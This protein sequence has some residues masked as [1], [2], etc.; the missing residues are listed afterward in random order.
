MNAAGWERAKS[1]LADAAALPDADRERF[2]VERCP[3]LELRREVLELLLSPAP[4]RDIVAA[5]TLHPGARIG[6]YVID[7]L[8]GRGGMGEV[9]RATDTNLKR[10]VAIKVLPAAVSSDPDRLARF[11][12]EAEV[13]AALNHPNVAHIHGLEKADG[14]IALVMEL[15]EGPTL[16][17]RIAQGA[18]RLDET[19]PIA[20]QIAEALEAAH[21]Q[22]II[23]R[24]LKP[25]NIKVRDDGTVKVLDFGLA[26]AMDPMASSNIDPA[27]SPTISVH[28]TQAGISLGTAAYMSPEQAR[29]KVV[30]KRTD[31]WAFG[32]VLFEMLTGCRTF[33]GETTSDTIA[34]ILEREPAWRALPSTVPVH[35][36]RL[37]ERC[38]NKDPKRRLRDIGDARAMLD[39]APV[40]GPWKQESTFR[41][42]VARAGW[43]I[44]ASVLAVGAAFGV[45]AIRSRLAAGP[46]VTRV[47]RLVSGPAFEHSPAISPD[48]KWVAY[49]SD[50][51]GATDVW[52]KV[53]PGGDPINLTAATNLDVAPQ[54]D[55]G[56]LSISPDGTLIAFNASL[57]GAP[58][59]NAAIGTWAI[60]APLGGTPRRVLEVGRG[61]RWSP[62]G[63][64]LSFI[65]Q[66]GPGG[67]AIW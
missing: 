49:L 24:D 32:C 2:I 14:T 31:I 58:S 56:G 61:A 50:A 48:G 18:I 5:G 3:D 62:D 37:M 21:E 25:S 53:I 54:V 4:L 57:R 40:A 7:G 52:V 66:G 6:P 42:S 8:L 23:H 41:D 44:A 10:Q 65:V 12:R 39:E 30:D 36:R 19:L 51:R 1:L 45:T 64:R 38:L 29:G 27:M 59:G 60:P 47:V 28:A 26:K 16:A 43:I 55:S 17:D 13:L 9:Y 11:Q 67:D 33:G 63:S 35:V 34:A 22:G 46:T 15:V 20:K